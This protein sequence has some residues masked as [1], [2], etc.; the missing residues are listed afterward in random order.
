MPNKYDDLMVEFGSDSKQIEERITELDRIIPQLEKERNQLTG[1]FAVMQKVLKR[2][3][4][5]AANESKGNGNDK[6]SVKKPADGENGGSIR[7][8]KD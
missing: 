1:M 7:K 6:N 3:E 5:G 8:Q 4:E 2:G